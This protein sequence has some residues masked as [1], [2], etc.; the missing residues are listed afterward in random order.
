MNPQ[1][2]AHQDYDN[3]SPGWGGPV[4]A[5]H[6]TIGHHEFSCAPLVSDGGVPDEEDPP[7]MGEALA[8][9]EESGGVD[10]A[11]S[12]HNCFVLKSMEH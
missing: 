12:E 8:R 6:E 11:T 4:L 9:S 5:C 2:S 1:G 7:T 10:S 3:H